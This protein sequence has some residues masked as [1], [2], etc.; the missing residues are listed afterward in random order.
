MTAV[1]NEFVQR[2]G[3]ICVHGVGLSVDVYSP[4]LLLVD[5]L[6]N[7]RGIP[8]DYYEVFQA[9]LPALTAVRE[10]LA[11]RCLAYHGEGLWISQPE[12]SARIENGSSISDVCGQL[13]T[14]KSQWLNIEC[15]TKQVAGVSFG[16]YL[17]PLYTAEGAVVAGDN[18]AALQ[19]TIDCAFGFG[20]SR[21]P[22]VLLE[23]PPLTYF[24]CGSLSIPS[25]FQEIVGRASCGLVLDIGHLWTVY[26]Y[27][28]AWRF[29]SVE[30]FLAAFL[31]SFP[32]ERVIEIH[33][34]GLAPHPAETEEHAPD[35]DCGSS[36]PRWIDAHGQPI[37]ALLF[38]ML[39]QVLS[40]PRL[41]ALKGL[42][43]EVDTK[44]PALIL[45]EFETFHRRFGGFFPSRRREAQTNRD[46]SVPAACG[47]MPIEAHPERGATR[48]MLARDYDLYARVVT[49]RAECSRLSGLVGKISDEEG[50]A[51][52]QG[53]YLPHEIL[54]WGGD[55]QDMFPRTCRMAGEHAVDIR[56][57]VAFWFKRTRVPAA[58][59][60]FFLLKIEYFVE[61]IA[62]VL[63]DASAEAAREAEELRAAYESVNQRAGC[64]ETAT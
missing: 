23:M 11:G 49:G 17:P 47:D 24:A 28:G 2:A 9:A 21:P 46:R 51:R 60:D 29:Q 42:A 31:D 27:T 12:F 64:E 22:L 6:L 55:L 19:R 26:R 18:A 35:Y 54:H 43:L 63:P 3:S 34:A 40:H 32:L 44:E 50:L 61:F 20:T 57:F 14:L 8:V 5:E 4:D 15:A 48:E 52:Y 58:A 41:S 16:T 38:D 45:S 25:F 1:Q 36:L 62:S 53:M 37:P 7:R 33:V 10:R 39:D 13:G 56:D 59:Y 30:R